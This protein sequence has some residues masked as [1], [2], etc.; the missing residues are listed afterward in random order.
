MIT[1]SRISRLFES[2]RSKSFRE[3]PSKSNTVLDSSSHA[4]KHVRSF[5]QRFPWQSPGG[6][7]IGNSSPSVGPT[8]P[9]SGGKRRSLVS[10]SHAPDAAGTFEVLTPSSS[11]RAP[12]PGSSSKKVIRKIVEFESPSSQWSNW[13]VL[14]ATTSVDQLPGSGVKEASPP[15]P[16]GELAR[17]HSSELPSDKSVSSIPTSNASLPESDGGSKDGAFKDS[18]TPAAEQ[19]TDLRLSFSAGFGGAVSRSSEMD[20]GSMDRKAAAEVNGAKAHGCPAKK[21]RRSSM[22]PFARKTVARLTSSPTPAAEPSGQE[23]YEGTTPRSLIKIA[24]RRFS[25]SGNCSTA[26]EAPSLPLFSDARIRELEA[27]G[28]VKSLS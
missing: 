6:N 27:A 26:S 10:P 17:E 1:G 23:N 7:V 9:A 15:R 18:S 13:P 3:T 2:P 16:S 21:E 24:S 22:F 28:P 8:T 25:R 14:G 19:I 4:S 12:T 11:K 20:G 5:S